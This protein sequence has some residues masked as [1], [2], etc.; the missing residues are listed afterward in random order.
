M[1][2]K[3]K[4]LVW[5]HVPESFSLGTNPYD[6]AEGFGGAYVVECRADGR[7]DMWK[8]NLSNGDRFPDIE[9]AKAAAQADYEA[10]ILSAIEAVDPATIRAE[11]SPPPPARG[12]ARPMPDAPRIWPVGGYAP[13]SYWCNCASCDQ[14]FMGDKRAYQCHDCVIKALKFRA[15]LIDMD[16][17]A[18]VEAAL[19]D[20]S[21]FL[22]VSDEADALLADL[23]AMMEKMT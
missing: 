9:A 18:R 11:A 17:L 1:T 14:T 3:V 5:A 4:P 13:G 2:I 20:Y 16:V 23:R 12:G 8:P 19:E 10:R 21:H 6:E 7:F 15:D 22:E